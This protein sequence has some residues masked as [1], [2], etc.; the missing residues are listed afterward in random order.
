VTLGASFS[1]SLTTFT[2]TRHDQFQ[3]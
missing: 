3:Q 1:Q 2:S